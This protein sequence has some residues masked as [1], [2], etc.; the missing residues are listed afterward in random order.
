VLSLSGPLMVLVL[1]LIVDATLGALPAA[2]H[3]GAWIDRVVGALGRRWPALAPVLALLLSVSLAGA[4][5]LLGWVNAPDP[6]VLAVSVWLLA[7]CLELPPREP[8]PGS[9]LEH[10]GAHFVAP[11]FWYALFGLPGAVFQRAMRACDGPACTWMIAAL[12]FVPARLTVG[13][14]WAAGKA[15]GL[16]L[17]DPARRDPRRDSDLRDPIRSAEVWR[18]ARLAAWIAAAVAAL[19]LYPRHAF[20]L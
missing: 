2:L 1:A 8:G 6:I 16:D 10:L 5:L 15:L 17:R 14:M 11:L 18:A 4:A 7:A 19:S 12:A 3:P 20:L 9:P 13:L